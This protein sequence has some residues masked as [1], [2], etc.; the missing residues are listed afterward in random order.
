MI[1]LNVFGFEKYLAHTCVLNISIVRNQPRVTKSVLCCADRIIFSFEIFHWEPE[2]VHKSFHSNYSHKNLIQRV[3]ALFGCTWNARA[4][5]WNWCTLQMRFSIIQNNDIFCCSAFDVKRKRRE[6]K[7]ENGFNFIQHNSPA[8]FYEW[9]CDE[10]NVF[11]KKKKYHFLE[12][13]IIM[14]C[15][16]CISSSNSFN[17]L[18]CWFNNC[19]ETPISVMQ[20]SIKCNK[21]FLNGWCWLMSFWAHVL[22]PNR[23]AS[24]TC[25]WVYEAAYRVGCDVNFYSLVGYNC[26]ELEKSRKS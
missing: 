9:H 19:D 18:V 13:E 20:N 2:Q 14:F 12:W 17:S 15:I 8:M 7:F 11:I 22:C 26:I 1:L 25:T 5:V 23:Y 16:A 24:S 4:E 10:T 6:N 21:A 3:F